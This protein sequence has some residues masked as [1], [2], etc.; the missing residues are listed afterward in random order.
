MYAIRELTERFVLLVFTA[1][2]TDDEMTDFVADIRTLV[3]GAPHSLAFLTDNR[4]SDVWPKDAYDKFVWAMRMDN[5]KVLA[6]IF[7]TEAG[8]PVEK[9]T[10]AL[11]AEGK[12]PARQVVTSV[13]EARTLLAPH[14]RRE[15]ERAFDD[16]VA[17]R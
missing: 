14:F 3:R 5:P 7:V 1:P 9:M 13:E 11:V 4:Q 17:E 6:N 15:D 12:N 8:S 2:V 10:R 16:Y